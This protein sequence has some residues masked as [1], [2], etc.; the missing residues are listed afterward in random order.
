VKLKRVVLNG[1]VLGTGL[2]LIL[3]SCCPP[4]ED[5]KV[6]G[7]L[8]DS[9]I[10]GVDYD[11]IEEGN[12][13]T[14]KD[15]KFECNKLPVT[16]KIGGLE[17]G[18]V[19]SLSDDSKV[20]PQDLVGVSRENFTDNRLILLTRFLQSL[21]DD[22]IISER[23]T[24]EKE[25][26]EKFSI[27]EFSDL[28]EDEIKDLL[29]Q[30]DKSLV[31]RD[32]ALSHLEDNLLEEE[33]TPNVPIINNS[34]SP[35]TINLSCS[36]K[37]SYSDEDDNYR[38]SEMKVYTSG[39]IVA[40]CLDVGKDKMFTGYKLKDGIDT[41][42]I[43][44]IVGERSIIFK[45]KNASYQGISKYDYKQGTIE[46]KG[47]HT[48]DSDTK[49]EECVNKYESILPKR[50]GIGREIGITNLLNWIDEINQQKSLSTT[51]PE[52]KD[53][54]D[55]IHDNNTSF[56][57]M[58][59][60]Y[61]LIDS[62][63]K[64]HLLTTVT[65]SKEI[66]QSDIPKDETVTKASGLSYIN[67]L[68]SK[69]NF[70][71]DI[72]GLG[73]SKE[74]E[75]RVALLPY[76]EQGKDISPS[77]K[78]DNIVEHT[79]DYLKISIHDFSLSFMADS[80][81]MEKINQ[82]PLQDRSS[83]MFEIIGERPYQGLSVCIAKVTKDNGHEINGQTYYGNVVHPCV[84]VADKNYVIHSPFSM[85]S[86]R[87]ESVGDKTKV[88]VETEGK[89]HENIIGFFQFIQSEIRTLPYMNS[90]AKVYPT[91]ES[92]TSFSF[93]MPDKI[94]GNT[95]HLVVAT[96]GKDGYSRVSDSFTFSV[97]N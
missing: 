10:E 69:L 36:P 66:A 65:T 73:I 78:A 28:S 3:G 4:P 52:E 1:L 33:D 58:K 81:D 32:S 62:N 23:I 38:S 40:N 9:P 63:N 74:D 25:I 26:G 2:A 97:D 13:T 42:E 96:F 7:Y 53:A 83:G 44:Q 89:L 91:K 14:D 95:H 46:Q 68:D 85:K 67:Y 77:D 17:L 55:T 59:T 6:V 60:N 49:Q 47:T 51:C 19:S 24:I 20:Y 56:F 87:T 57:E 37:I 31:G 61:T 16:F 34:W 11:C 41:L 90:L 12:G 72:K 82:L 71:V 76:S 70:E 64:K 93:I 50:I 48:V 5:N 27:T 75:I 18:S 22:G 79:D 88:I 15:G 8:V 45:S 94:Q 29:T 43:V 86:I 39:D 54:N 84:F 92:E 21:D 30:V 35:V 80:K